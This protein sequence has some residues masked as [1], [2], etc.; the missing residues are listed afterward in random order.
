[1]QANLPVEHHLVGAIFT[2]F[3]ISAALLE[4]V[5]LF[6]LIICLLGVQEGIIHNAPIYWLN[7][8]SYL[9]FAAMILWTFPTKERLENIFKERFLV[10]NFA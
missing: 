8:F 4:G 3:I 2:S 10:H 9:F 5:A 7:L 1:M 6:G